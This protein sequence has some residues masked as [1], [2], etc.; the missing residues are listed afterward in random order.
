MNHHHRI[1]SRYLGIAVLLAFVLALGGCVRGKR[2]F[3]IVQLCMVDQ[4]DVAKF[5]LELRA[6][7]D[8]ERMQFVDNSANTARDL[9]NMNYSGEERTNG[10]QVINI[11]V[12]NR[13][14][15]GMTANN[16]GLPGYQVAIGFS[17]GANPTMARRFANVVVSRLEQYWRVYT[18][19]AGQGAL[20]RQGCQ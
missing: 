14:G 2:P 5:K 6:I 18:V 17:E 16:V 1:I 9:G 13:E 8:L 7:A 12:D 4:S 20:P 11:G 3:L 19:P 15:F 10:S